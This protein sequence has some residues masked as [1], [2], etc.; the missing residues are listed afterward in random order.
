MREEKVITHRNGTIQYLIIHLAFFFFFCY[1]EQVS[2][3][4]FPFAQ[5]TLRMSAQSNTVSSN[6]FDF[7]EDLTLF[8][9]FSL[10]QKQFNT[11]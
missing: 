6:K 2:V 8:F 7:L 9:L 3:M 1:C 5:S 10:L 4:T 11:R